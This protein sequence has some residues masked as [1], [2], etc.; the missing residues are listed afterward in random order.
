MENR[1]K[2]NLDLHIRI[3]KTFGGLWTIFSLMDW[4]I[5][6]REKFEVPGHA[7]NNTE[8]GGCGHNGIDLDTGSIRKI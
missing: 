8:D 7:W 3:C 5:R 2:K 6:V 1:V 4:A